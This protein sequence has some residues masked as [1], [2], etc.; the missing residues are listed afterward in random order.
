MVQWHTAGSWWHLWRRWEWKCVLAESESVFGLRRIA[1][2][3]HFF[4]FF[5]TLTGKGV[6]IELKND[7]RLK[8]VLH[9]VDQY[10]NIKL[11]EVEVVDPDLYPH[12]VRR[13]ARSPRCCVD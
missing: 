9:S 1:L 2:G 13:D 10:L 11:D 12:M 5:K 8:G 3:M 7:L 4:S 6:V